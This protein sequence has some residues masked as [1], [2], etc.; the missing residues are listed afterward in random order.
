MKMEYVDIDDLLFIC[1]S[2]KLK[3]E[4]EIYKVKHK[5][6]GFNQKTNRNFWVYVKTDK[7]KEIL[8]NW[9]ENKDL[10]VNDKYFK[11]NGDDV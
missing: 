9:S 3:E 2:I 4:F 11:R 7:V 5:V 8:I 10:Y 6:K 1:Y